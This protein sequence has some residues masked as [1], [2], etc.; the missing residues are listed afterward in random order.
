V[1]LNGVEREYRP[2]LTL[3]ALLNE[4]GIDARKVVVMHGDA[5]YRAGEVPDAPVANGD[6]VEIVTMMQG[7]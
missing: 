3:H 6:V 1:R 4:L 5:I 7:G 2:G